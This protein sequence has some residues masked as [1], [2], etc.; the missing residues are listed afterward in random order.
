MRP[1]R[2]KRIEH[3]RRR[4]PHDVDHPHGRGRSLTTPGRPPAWVAALLAVSGL[5]ALYLEPIRTR[6]LND[7]YLFLEEARTRP[8]AYSLTHLGAL[9]NYWRPLSRQIYFEALAPIQGGDPLVFHAVNFMLFL[10]ALALVF[11]LLQALLPASGA[12]IGTIGFALLPF[13][14][15]NLTWVSCSQDLMALVSTLATV[16]L[17]RRGRVA[18]AMLTSLAAFAS[19]EAALPLPVALVAWSALVEAQGWRSAARRAAPFGILAI[20]WVAVAQAIVSFGGAPAF[21]HFDLTHF[22]AGYVHLVQSVLGLETMESVWPALLRNGPSIAALVLLAPLAFWYESASRANS[23]GTSRG[24]VIASPAAPMKGPAPANPQP[25]APA[26]DAGPALRYALAWLLAFGL[27]AGPVASTWSSYYYTTAAV[28]GAVLLGLALRRGD[29]W[30]WILAI[31]VLL[32]WHAA[33]NSVAVF[34]VK[35]DPW[36]RTSHLTSFYFRRAATITDSLSRQLRALE[37]A[38]PRDSR[39]FFATL[40]PWAGFQMGNGALVR[41]LY[42]DETLGSWFYT[43]FSEST[44]ADHPVRFLYWDGVRLEGLYPRQRDRFFQVGTDLLLLDRP[45]G[46]VHAF[47]RGLAAGEERMDHLYW[48]AWAQLWRGDR[49]SAETTWKQFG[50]VDDSLYWSAHLRAAHNALIDGDS[51]EARRHLIR[52][53]EFGMGRPEGHAALGD[54]LLAERPKYATLEHKVA[55][56]LKPNDWMSRRSLVLG[57]ADA[58][59]DDQARHEFEALAKVYPEWRSDS[60]VVRAWRTIDARG[61]HGASVAKF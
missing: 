5:A 55:S 33:S 8:L 6:F 61:V 54:L 37:P 16:A 22:V 39:F 10:V 7:D 41:D 50:A 35:D 53:I 57:L 47:R 9:G 52:A 46:A 11:D 26:P 48:L 31:A 56:W 19:K 4:E 58:R 27:V 60:M 34:A 43:Q 40:P 42:R 12:L 1:M 45:A 51:L 21:L 59:L 15:V 32:W 23:P 2:R 25:F 28:G 38:P 36:G 14:R 29:R 49:D 30:T 13:Q 3:Q 17:Y 18:L 20:A 44:A 24:A